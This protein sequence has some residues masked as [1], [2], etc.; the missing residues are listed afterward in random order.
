MFIKNAFRKPY[1]LMFLGIA[2]SFCCSSLVNGAIPSF[3][4]MGELSTEWIPV[5]T[6]VSGILS[7]MGLV[8]ARLI[9]NRNP[10][11]IIMACNLYDIFLSVLAAFSTTQHW[12]TSQQTL[13]SYLLLI[14][15][16]PIVTS[17]SQQVYSGELSITST[18]TSS[19]FNTL[20][21]SFTPFMSLAIS[22]AA[23]SLLAGSSLTTIIFANIVLSSLSF[24]FSLN[25]YRLSRYVS[26]TGEKRREDEQLVISNKTSTSE[27][28]ETPS[29]RSIKC[30]LAHAFKYHSLKEILGISAHSPI[31]IGLLYFTLD[32]YL[33]YLPVW[34]SHQTV[35]KNRTVAAV[36][37]LSGIGSTVGPI[38]YYKWRQRAS[39][40]RHAVLAIAVILLA[41]LL[42][43]IMVN[44]SGHPTRLFVGLFGMLILLIGGMASYASMALMGA[45][46]EAYARD[47]YNLIVGIAYSC[48]SLAMIAGSWTGF[49]MSAASS[50][51]PALLLAFI[52]GSLLLFAIQRGPAPISR[53]HSQ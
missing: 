37:F 33:F 11:R 49:Y 13:C 26:K 28:S 48:L 15:I 43:L 6:T 2:F 50:P 20:S 19:F 17:I 52:L 24:L 22:S 10:Y 18:S 45:R 30:S 34:I 9:E 40:K 41:E 31:T 8:I 39:F 3:V 7:A 16:T 14:S 42:L 12:L 1:F 32:I 51:F 5:L 53:T 25:A 23:G 36:N 21:F 35:H 4:S 46:Q 29:T 44:H 47:R 27:P 38:L